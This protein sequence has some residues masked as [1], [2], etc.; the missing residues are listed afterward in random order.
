MVKPGIF[1]LLDYAAITTALRCG[2]GYRGLPGDA[3]GSLE[4]TLRQRQRRGFRLGR[5]TGSGILPE[6][7]RAGEGCAVEGGHGRTRWRSGPRARGAWFR[8]LRAPAHELLGD[9]GPA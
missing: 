1:L 5:R 4:D 3:V 7:G 2:R 6:C 9:P 8:S